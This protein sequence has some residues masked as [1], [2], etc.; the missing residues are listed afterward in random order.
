MTTASPLHHIELLGMPL[1]RLDEN[2]LLD[3]MFGELRRGRGGWRSRRPGLYAPLHERA[4]GAPLYAKAR[5]V[6]DGIRWWGVVAPGEPLPERVA[7]S[8]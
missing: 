4:C 3:H 6:A 1:A 5:L 2:G 8:G 7:G